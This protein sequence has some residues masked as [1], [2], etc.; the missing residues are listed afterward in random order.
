MRGVRAAAL[1][2]VLVIACATPEPPPTGVVIVS[3]DTLRADAL[4]CYGQELPVS[5]E[6]DR[7]AGTST[8]FEQAI[9]PA[10]WTL[11]AHASML[12]GTTPLRHGAIDATGPIRET[13]ATLAERLAREGFWT[14]AVVNAPFL[15]PVYG[16]DRGFD[17]YVIVKRRD[18]VQVLERRMIE[19]VRTAQNLRLP[20]FLFLHTMQAHSPYLPPEETDRFHDPSRGPVQIDARR[21]RQL[22]D[23]M[24]AGDLELSAAD[25]DF[26]RAKYLGEVSA[27]DAMIGRLLTVL[28][29]VLGRGGLLI[30]T[31][32]H[33]EEF[34]EHGALQHNDSV[35]EELMR[36]PLLLRGPGFPAGTRVESLVSTVDVTP[37][38]LRWAGVASGESVLD[39]RVLQEASGPS[40]PEREVLLLG[41]FP[42]EEQRWL[43]L[44]SPDWKLVWDREREN[45]SFYDL[46]AD[47]LETSPEAPPRVLSELLDLRLQ[48]IGETAS[49]GSAPPLSLAPDREA[50]LRALGY[51]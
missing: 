29:P 8:L 11:P 7:L 42:R 40:D 35:F 26:L 37:T 1:L 44:R 15:D 23:A 22:Q 25:L 48:T 34:L 16:F 17:R 45:R 14:G 51:L 9:S 13:V 28:D 50:E 24:R 10:S 6:I 21:I 41:G 5:P 43:G 4:G 2:A 47:P 31:S 18:G 19:L 20:F 39:G 36:V 49:D 3:I 32:D 46:R 27:V 12:T 30:L 38:V 33:G